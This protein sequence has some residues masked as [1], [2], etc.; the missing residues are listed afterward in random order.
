MMTAGKYQ[1]SELDWLEPVG[2]PYFSQ[3]HSSPLDSRSF[4]EISPSMMKFYL[5]W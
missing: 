1:A 4:S 5:R 3:L 2:Q